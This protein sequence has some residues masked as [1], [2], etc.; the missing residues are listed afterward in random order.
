MTRLNTILSV[1]GLAALLAAA[2]PPDQERTLTAEQ[3][4]RA[5]KTGN[6]HHQRHKYSHP[7]ETL[8]RQ[9]ELVAGQHPHSMILSCSDSRVPPE[10]IF[11]QGLGDLFTVRVAGNVV[12]DAV[13]AS[14]EYAVEHLHTHLLAVIG[15][16]S[17]GAVTAAIEGGDAPGHL[18]TL[19]GAIRPSVE[20]AKAQSGKLIDNAIRL[21]VEAAIEQLQT[22]RPILSEAIAKGELQ[23]VGGVVSLE[24]GAVQWLPA[25]ARAASLAEH[26]RRTNQIGVHR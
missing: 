8:A 16:Q 13:I 5:L 21:N 2:P 7:H 9:R 10:V 25:K 12:D 6:E 20:R 19:I 24:T 23:I 14:F 22:S 17:C 3:A 26:P 18:P 1:G 15:H 11:D 4:L